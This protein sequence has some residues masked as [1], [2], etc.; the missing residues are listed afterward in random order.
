MASAE[1]AVVRGRP[2]AAPIVPAARAA[3]A[4]RLLGSRTRRACCGASPRRPRARVSPCPT[5][6]STRST[7]APSRT[8]TRA[9]ARCAQRYDAGEDA[10]D[11]APQQRGRARG[12]ALRRPLELSAAF[13]CRARSSASMR[14]RSRTSARSPSS[15]PPGSAT[16]VDRAGGALV[17]GVRPLR[18]ARWRAGQ[19]T[20]A[21]AAL[22]ARRR[23]AAARQLR[24]STGPDRALRRAQQ[25]GRRVRARRQALP[26]RPRC[27]G[28][29]RR[30]RGRGGGLTALAR[31]LAGCRSRVR[32]SPGIPAPARSGASCDSRGRWSSCAHRKRGR[33]GARQQREG[34]ACP[35]GD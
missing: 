26:Q 33:R 7:T 5:T 16:W 23:L 13:R 10:L 4:R 22:E 3:R 24:L 14:R 28:D 8:T 17:G 1:P 18:G 30:L 31:D 12:C 11:R 34:P 15:E 35:R 2:S 27:A 32:A 20:R 25:L 29:L 9:P 19:G 6:P 21:H